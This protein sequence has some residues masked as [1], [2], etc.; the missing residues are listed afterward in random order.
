MPDFSVIMVPSDLTER[1]RES[2]AA[3]TALAGGSGSPRILVVHVR[4]GHHEPTEGELEVLKERLAD[5][6]VSDPAIQVEHLVLSGHP[7]DQI[8]QLAE[9]TQCGLI[10]IATYAR[11]G[12]D[13][14]MMGSVAEEVV[15]HAPCSVLCVKSPA[16]EAGPA[17]VTKIGSFL[18]ID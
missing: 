16:T 13:R 12:L 1:T 2:L 9:E 3:A 6:Q 10:V 17:P 14:M 11:A 15:R 4:E 7:A 5:F 18:E 8:L